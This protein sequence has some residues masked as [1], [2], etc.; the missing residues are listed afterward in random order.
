MNKRTLSA[1]AA[2]CCIAVPAKADE[3]RTMGQAASKLVFAS[4][5]TQGKGYAHMGD[6][7][8]FRQSV[9]VSTDADNDGRITYAEFEAW[10][11]GFDD[12]ALAEGRPEAIT[13][14]KRIIFSLWDRNAD[15]IL[16]QSEHRFSVMSDF[17]RAD[18]DD[19]GT[20][21][22]NEFLAG[23]SMIVALR[24]AIRPDIDVNAQ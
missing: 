12:V 2:L 18:S 8:Q 11:P 17:Q 20:L 4:I 19:D 5:D 10:N 23:F 22:E 15:N 14:A 1:L 21:T 16:S 7:E 3:N 24:A 9:F 13:T 6:L